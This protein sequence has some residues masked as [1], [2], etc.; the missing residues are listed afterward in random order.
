MLRH[1]STLLSER[2]ARVDRWLHGRG[3]G[4]ATEVVGDKPTGGEHVFIHKSQL[5]GHDHLVPGQLVQ[6][7]NAGTSAASSSAPACSSASTAAS[8]K[9]PQP[10]VKVVRRS[11]REWVLRT[12]GRQGVTPALRSGS[13]VVEL[14]EADFG[15]KDSANGG[16]SICD[17]YAEEH[18]NVFK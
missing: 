1:S 13:D 4:F 16:I 2:L 10:V 8:S 17:L 12:I 6:I 15:P 9:Q 14:T 11:S 3:Y 18:R 5:L 7:T